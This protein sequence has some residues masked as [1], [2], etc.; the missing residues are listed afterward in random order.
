MSSPRLANN[1]FKYIRPMKRRFQLRPMKDG[2]Q[3]NLGL[4]LTEHEAR[5]AYREWLDGRRL[6]LPRGTR[7]IHTR[8]G[9]RFLGGVVYRGSWI[10]VRELLESR[11]EA[12]AAIGRLLKRKLGAKAAARALKGYPPGKRPR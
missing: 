1:P 10:R 2:I 12:A 11:E 4:F 7:R 3:L 5:R 9:E 8:L 6:P